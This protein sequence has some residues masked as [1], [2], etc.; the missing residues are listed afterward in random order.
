MVS[1][2]A[3]AGLPSFHSF[4]RSCEAWPQHF[5]PVA[6]SSWRTSHCCTNCWCSNAQPRRLHSAMPIGQFPVHRDSGQRGAAIHSGTP[7]EFFHVAAG[8]SYCHPQ[9]YQGDTGKQL[10]TFTGNPGA[11]AQSFNR[12]L[13][14]SSSCLPRARSET[15]RPL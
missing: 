2:S 14:S 12:R 1:E 10:T 4:L 11:A 15:S 8:W 5:T 7:T 3:Q 9:G 6:T 13:T